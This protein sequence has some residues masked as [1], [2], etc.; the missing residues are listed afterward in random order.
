[1]I[2]I[3]SLKT[4]DYPNGSNGM[5]P[6]IITKIID[7][8]NVSLRFE[9]Y[10][11]NYSKFKFEMQTLHRAKFENN[12]KQS[13]R[14]KTIGSLFI[15]KRNS[16]YYRTK[17]LETWSDGIY[18]VRLLDEGYNYLAHEEELY[19]VDCENFATLPIQAVTFSLLLDN[20]LMHP[21]CRYLLNYV[22]QKIPTLQDQ[23]SLKYSSEKNCI[24]LF[25]KNKSSII[26]VNDYLKSIFNTDM[27]FKDFHN[28]INQSEIIEKVDAILLDEDFIVSNFITSTNVVSNSEN[29]V[30]STISGE[31]FV[32]YNHVNNKDDCS[33]EGGKE[34]TIS[35][36]FT[37]MGESYLMKVKQIE[38]PYKF[39]VKFRKD[40]EYEN[41]KKLLA[42]HSAN[43]SLKRVDQPKINRM[44]GVKRSDKLIRVLILRFDNLNNSYECFVVD[45]GYED[46]FLPEDIYDLPENLKSFAPRSVCARL[47]FVRPK[48]DKEEW[49]PDS[50]N[51]FFMKAFNN[52][53]EVLCNEYDNEKHLLHCV[54]ILND[55]NLAEEMVCEEMADY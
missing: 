39:Y 23:F 15:L 18:Y 41:L 40:G 31:K 2:K 34:L 7:P 47:N 27:E 38:S 30:S 8:K 52:E 53:V 14:I 11:E 44:Y 13:D 29:E 32:D 46:R 24:K 51:W 3:D 1:M 21:N 28:S 22:L 37:E 5:V 25:F 20:D 43:F 17:I 48:N 45:K 49:D 4:V 35:K 26:S 16:D 33:D 12:L 54:L 6:C 19:R 50:C 42:E 10:E 55:N 9:C 36:L